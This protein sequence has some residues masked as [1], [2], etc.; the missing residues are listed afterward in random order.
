MAHVEDRWWKSAG[1]KRVKTARHGTG[2]RWRAR[3]LNPDGDERSRS[4]DRKVDAERFI[5]EVEHSKIA[6]SYRDPDAGRDRT[7]H[8]DVRTR[9]EQQHQTVPD[10]GLVVGEHE[11]DHGATRITVQPPARPARRTSPG[12]HCAAR[13]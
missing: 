10:H 12:R 2:R 8:L 11:P 7:H 4:F 6:G 3:Y 5:A 1:G 9:A 13:Q